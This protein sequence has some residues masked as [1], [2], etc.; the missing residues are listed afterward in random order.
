MVMMNEEELNA[1]NGGSWGYNIL[2]DESKYNNAGVKTEWSKNPFKQDKFY[3]DG[4]EID[5]CCSSTIVFYVAKF[6]PKKGSFDRHDAFNYASNH[7]AEY[8]AF[9][10]A[11]NK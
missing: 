4:A 9:I 10:E 3:F 6:N 1:V 8:K 5:D 11:S 7:Y 2:H